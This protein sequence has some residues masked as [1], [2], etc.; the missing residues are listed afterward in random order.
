[1]GTSRILFKTAMGNQVFD[2][3]FVY[4]LHTVLFTCS[5]TYASDTDPPVLN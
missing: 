4:A 3:P 5:R 2:S 1:M